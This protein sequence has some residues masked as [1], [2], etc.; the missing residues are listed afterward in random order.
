MGNEQ[1]IE[2]EPRELDIWLTEG[3]VLVD[4]DSSERLI[5]RRWEGGMAVLRSAKDGAEY[6]VSQS[7]VTT[8]K[9]VPRPVECGQVW[10]S[11]ETGDLVRIVDTARDAV[12]LRGMQPE[13]RPFWLTREPLVEYFTW[14]PEAGA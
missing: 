2:G 13:D 11:K 10:R 4:P 12:R 5:F 14:E 6:R 1:T 8:W 7:G 9:Y 3:V